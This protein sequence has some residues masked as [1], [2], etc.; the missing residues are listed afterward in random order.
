MK[1]PILIQLK[2]S[3]KN[4]FSNVSSFVSCYLLLL[5]F[6]IAVVIIENRKI[7]NFRKYAEQRDGFLRADGLNIDFGILTE[8]DKEK[9]EIKK[10]YQSLINNI[11][12]AGNIVSIEEDNAHLNPHLLKRAVFD[13]DEI[14]D[15]ENSNYPSHKAQ[16]MIQDI[17]KIQSKFTNYP[18]RI[19]ISYRLSDMHHNNLNLRKIPYLITQFLRSGVERQFVTFNIEYSNKNMI[20]IEFSFD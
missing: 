14:F 2:E 15:Q 4:E 18:I 7:E 10:I 1:K 9:I 12:P 8:V 20:E 11:V 6:F 17:V 3:Q 16:I 5:I 19:N 13:L